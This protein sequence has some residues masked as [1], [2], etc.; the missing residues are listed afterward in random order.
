MTWSAE[1]MLHEE[2]TVT[3]LAKSLIRARDAGRSGQ[4]QHQ[5]SSTAKP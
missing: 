2:R 5:K 3:E 4:S 1:D